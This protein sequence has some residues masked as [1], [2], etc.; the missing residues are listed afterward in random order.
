MAQI[1]AVS[2]EQLSLFD[3]GVDVAKL[4]SERARLLSMRRSRGTHKAY[5]TDWKIF[6][7]WCEAAGREPF[8]ASTDS[9]CL[10]ITSE[11]AKGLKVSTVERRF[12][13]ISYEHKHKGSLVT[14]ECRSECRQ[15]F[16]AARRDRR[17]RKEG[18]KALQVRDLAR[19]SEKLPE[20]DTGIR[21]RALLVFG[22]ASGLRRSELARLDLKDITFTRRGIQVDIRWSKTDQQARGRIFGIF[23]GER[24]STDPVRTLKA[25]LHVRGKEPGPLFTRIAPGGRTVTLERVS[26]IAVNRV[27]KRAMR[28]IGADPREYSAHSLRAGLVTAAAENGA[29]EREIMRASGHKSVEVMRQY[30]RPVEAFPARN[31]LAGAL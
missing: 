28:S 3:S 13:S 4:R 18:K 26:D 7:E 29:S 12:A 21:D 30:V 19:I 23:P 27:V 17:E 15:L 2:N 14:P 8:P 6:L 1:A 24:A 10:F 5:S 11:L 31:P 16:S 20:T 22:L 25:W 9:I